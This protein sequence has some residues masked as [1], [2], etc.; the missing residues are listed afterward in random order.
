M[1]STLVIVVVLLYTL[2][3]VFAVRPRR[4]PTT[5]LRSSMMV[6]ISL[7]LVGASAGLPTLCAGFARLSLRTLGPCRSKGSERHSGQGGQTAQSLAG[8]FQS[9]KGGVPRATAG[10]F[11]G[12]FGASPERVGVLG[13]RLRPKAGLILPRLLPDSSRAVV[14]VSTYQ[15]SPSLRRSDQGRGLQIL[16][17]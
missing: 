7:L 11:A 15:L 13:V 1:I 5:T 2:F 9:D 10:E 3:A 6:L 8:F 14:F 17:A 4:T 12:R 16:R